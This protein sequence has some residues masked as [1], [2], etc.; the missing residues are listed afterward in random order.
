MIEVVFNDLHELVLRRCPKLVVSLGELVEIDADAMVV[1]GIFSASYFAGDFI[2]RLY[3]VVDGGLLVAR[4]E[5]SS[6]RAETA[7]LREFDLADPGVFE[8]VVEYIG[9]WNDS[10]SEPGNGWTG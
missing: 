9:K 1:E 4:G 8:Q 3:F 7:V 5:D 10:P 2:E 6:H